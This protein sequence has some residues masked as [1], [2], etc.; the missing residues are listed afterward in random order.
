MEKNRVDVQTQRDRELNKGGKVT[1][2]EEEVKVLEKVWPGY[3]PKQILE[4]APS[5]TRRRRGRHLGVSSAWCARLLFSSFV[6][7]LADILPSS[8]LY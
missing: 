5:R 2:M 4:R 6:F 8:K 3:V 7:M 1:R